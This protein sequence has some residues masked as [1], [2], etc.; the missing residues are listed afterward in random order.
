MVPAFS[1]L[2][3][4]RATKPPV[5]FPWL[6]TAPAVPSL[7]NEYFPFMKSLSLMLRL[8][9]TRPPTLTLAPGANSTP[10]GLTR[11]TRPLAFSEPKMLEGLFPKTRL[12]RLDWLLGWEILTVSPL[13]MP[14]EFQLMIAWFDPW[15]IFIC[16]AEGE[17]MTACPAATCPP[18]GKASAPLAA[19]ISEV[20]TA[21][22]TVIGEGPPLPLMVS[23]AITQRSLALLQI[24]R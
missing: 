14:K 16:V 10:E 11:K 1:T 15:F 3:P 19:I 23:A 7:K 18:V 4:S 6:T 22:A 20:I 24:R 2:L 17:A 13:P 21:A 9:A 12:K 8:E 5:I